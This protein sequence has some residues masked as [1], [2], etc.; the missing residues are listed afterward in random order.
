MGHRDDSAVKASDLG[1]LRGILLR[2]EDQRLARLEAELLDPAKLSGHIA[3]VLAD[4]LRS[5]NQ[6]H[7][8]LVSALQDPTIE[9]ISIAA[10]QERERLSDALAP[11]IGPS[12][13]RA[14][15]DSL[16]KF[17]QSI[18]MIAQHNFSA[19]GVKWRLEAMRTGIPFPQVVLNH[20]L[21]FEVEQIYLI[22]KPSGL[23]VSHLMHPDIAA[24]D[25]DRD[26]VA[27]MMM[28]IQDFV[29]DSAFGASAERVQTIELQGKT[30]WM[31]HGAWALLACVI[32]GVPPQSLR[33]DINEVLDGIHGNFQHK[34]REFN[35][36]QGA[37]TD[38]EAPLK[39]LL[40]KELVSEQAPVKKTKGLPSWVK[41]L[42]AGLVL[43]VAYL[44]YVDYLQD[45]RKSRLETEL[46]KTP[47]VVITDI[48]HENGSWV[49]RG[50]ADPLSFD[51]QAILARAQLSAKHARLEFV[52]YVSLAPELVLRRA[53]AALLPPASVDL[54]LDGNVLRI[55]GSASAEWI[56]R[57]DATNATLLN[58]TRI[59]QSG[60]RIE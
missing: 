39:Q 31:C 27:G 57:L 28:A 52:P 16:Q 11:V 54:A 34:L 20:T 35:G 42:I 33:K 44:F 58:V 32:R 1:E 59:D 26:V 5:A 51:A 38:L 37:L 7:T 14:I 9:S 6:D 2:D 48:S 29:R 56:K 55:T 41:A 3:N 23:L 13:Q 21:K 46:K 30:V 10:R 12:I 53:T 15:V 4:S 36:D 60:L 50:M 49:A 18:E 24:Q 40:Q 43:L 19:R 45:A 22:Q 8:R 25:V 17:T 47:G